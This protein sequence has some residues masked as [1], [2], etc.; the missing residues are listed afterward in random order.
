MKTLILS[1]LH[2]NIYALEAIWKKEYDS[3]LIL[4]TGDLV[5][6]GIYPHQTL[7]WVR[8]HNVRCVQGNHDAWVALNYR[9]GNRLDRFPLHQREWV[10]YTVS[11][12]DEDDIQ[13]LERLPLSLSFELDG[14]AYGIKHLY[15]DY[16]EIVSLHAFHQFC[17]SAFDP[18]LSD[19]ITRL[20]LGHTH[21]QSVRY[22]SDECL[23][24]N[25]GSASYRRQDD[26]DQSTH[27]ATITDGKISLKRLRYD[28]S[29]L[30]HSLQQIQLKEPELQVAQFHFGPRES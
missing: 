17:M 16:K 1:D 8:Q 9:Q 13:Y 27:Y 23:W 26:P 11:L 7:T 14:I 15:Q 20:I 12:L 30:Y 2:A 18:A 21:R 3:E 25:P 6:Y 10:H 28:I 22:L 24:L 4:C 5:D 19:R 29:P